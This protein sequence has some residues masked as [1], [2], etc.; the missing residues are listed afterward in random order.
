MFVKF[1]FDLSCANATVLMYSNESLYS[2]Y[3]VYSVYMCI[4]IVEIT[5][6]YN[7]SSGAYSIYSSI[8][9]CCQNCAR[10]YLMLNP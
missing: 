9:R 6:V 3:S 7:L 1:E 4:C 5:A 8:D 2:L 10:Q